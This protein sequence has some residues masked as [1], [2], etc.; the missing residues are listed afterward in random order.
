MAILEPRNLTPLELILRVRKT[1]P[2]YQR[3]FVWEPSLITTFLE[4]IWDACD[5][6]MEKYF[7][8]S[9]VVFENHFKQYEIVDGQQRTTVLYI[10]ISYLIERIGTIKDDPEWISGER[11]SYIY[12]KNRQKD[13]EFYFSHQN[14]KLANFLEIVGLNKKLENTH[15]STSIIMK[16]LI[17]CSDAIHNFVENKLNESDIDKIEDFY[18]YLLQNVNFVHFISKDISEALLIYS[19]LN[20]GGKA[21]GHLEI[22]KGHLFTY[23]N[24]DQENWKKLESNWDTF[25]VKFSSEIKIGGKGTSKMLIPEH[26]F[27]SYFFLVKYPNLV[28]QT[29]NTNDGF[30][31]TN[32]ITE[33]LLN[34][35]VSN[36]IFANPLNFVEELTKFTHE[37]KTMRTGDQKG[38]N[39]EI[40]KDI[41]LLSQRQTQPL[42]FLLSASFD[43]KLFSALLPWAMRLVF[44][45]TISVKGTGKTSLVWKKLSKEIRVK[46]DTHKSEELIN[47]ITDLAK[48]ELRENWDINFKNFIQTCSYTHNKSDIKL[49]HLMNEIAALS[50]TNSP[51]DKNY[52]KFYGRSGF[53]VDHISPSNNSDEEFIQKLGNTS[54]FA[55]SDNRSLKETPFEDKEK[56]KEISKSELM[57]TRALVSDKERGSRN[58]IVKKFTTINEMN[59]HTVKLREKEITQC[60]AEYFE[61]IN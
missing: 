54:I 39:G 27:L 25:W 33:F 12:K 22:I 1:I 53:D 35:D 14:H 6:G 55:T 30:L 57:T 46:K 11:R 5:T 16:N 8:G 42:M 40:L 10:L 41:A 51:G 3:D 28:D 43:P 48:N 61:I 18:Q 29:C 21:L 34:K 32:K 26:T 37:I 20:S 4:N 7:C 50:L 58:N 9:M 59:E 44:V 13:N 2:A 56:R 45:F 19:R 60:I 23:Y 38:E 36:K 31:P 15:D 49:I 24:N 52:N 17:K 47:I